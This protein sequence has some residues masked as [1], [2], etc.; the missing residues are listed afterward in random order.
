MCPQTLKF[1][2]VCAHTQS[3]KNLPLSQVDV[4]RMK[5]LIFAARVASEFPIQDEHLVTR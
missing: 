4:N 2:L 1:F 3:K 5:A